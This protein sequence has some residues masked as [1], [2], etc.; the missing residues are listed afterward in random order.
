[1]ETAVDW[2]M[3]AQA[4]RLADWT[5]AAQIG[6]RA[7]GPGVP[8]APVARAKMREDFAELVPDSEE[9]I[10]GF[11][12]LRS[13]GFRARPWVMS[14]GDWID[15]NLRGLQ[16][17]L[18]PLAARILAGRDDRPEFR[19]KALGLQIGVLLG[20]VSKK[21]LGQYD[22]FLPPDDDGLL[23]FVGP[24]VAEAERRFRLQE[25]DFRLWLALHE[26]THR[27]QFGSASWLRRY[28]ADQ[29]ARYLNTIALD[30]RE[31]LRQLSRAVKQIRGGADWKGPNALLLLM[32][33]E[34]RE[35]FHRMQAV[36]SL[37]EGH[38]S[39]VMN[40]VADGHVRDLSL[41][42]QALKERRRSGGVERVFQRAIGFESKVRQYDA[43]ERFVAEVVERAGMNGLNLVWRGAPNLP[44]P[45]EIAAPE[46]WLE[47][48]APG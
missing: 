34:Q 5:V 14:R 13:D 42:R 37:L 33:P 2:S 36:M 28:L 18:E 47:R 7:A 20:Y 35:L 43:G 19:R 12:G 26:V 45:A 24:N 9:L 23:Y 1:M 44:T 46:R 3:G 22:V 25:R 6:R 21:V 38:A 41:M 39:F 40:R 4:T 17:M 31:M 48:V 32:T 15:A 29:I 27:I 30:G 11:T 10:A 8:V 16:R